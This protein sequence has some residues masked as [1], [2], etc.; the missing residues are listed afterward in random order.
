MSNPYSKR[1]VLNFNAT[2]GL[3]WNDDG[4]IKLYLSSKP[5]GPAGSKQLANWLPTAEN[6]PYW[7]AL[8]LFGPSREVVAGEYMLPPIIREQQ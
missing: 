2:P 7:A 5:P 6:E 1:S 4:S 8:R 3:Q